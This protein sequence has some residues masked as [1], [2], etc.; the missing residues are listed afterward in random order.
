MA[1]TVGQADLRGI[2]IDKAVKGFA[3]SE[4]IFKQF[5]T[6]TPTANREIRWWRKTAGVLDS[7]D[8][9]GITA[10]QIPSTA[11]GALPPIAEQSMTRL[12]SY[13]KHFA[14]ESPWFTYA[15]L[16]DS[17]PDVLAINIRDLTRAVV[18]QVDYRIFDVLSG[19]IALSGA[20]AVNTWGA[21]GNPI[22]DL[23]SGAKQIEKQNYDTSNLVVLMNPDQ[24]KKL[25][26]WLINTK[27]SSIPQFASEKVE[28]GVVMKIV[29]QRIVV[30]NNATTGMVMQIVPQRCATWK[31]FT[32]IT[33]A[34]KDEP[35][36]GVKI[37]IWE[38]GDC[39]V[40]DANAGYLIKGC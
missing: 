19:T 7:T 4:F 23:L 29:G 37:R 26:E 14:I 2:N 27:G 40:T 39:Y 1:D 36:I 35:G 38:D 8:T 18:N 17:D 3:D 9:T 10:S 11:F 16:R 6:V 32:P 30:S 5:L 21:D 33:A 13:V 24:K 20:A 28:S 31:S 25:I 12:T 22:G 34:T 15:D